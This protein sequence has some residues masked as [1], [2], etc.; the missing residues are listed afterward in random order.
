MIDFARRMLPDRSP[1]RLAYHK[2]KALLAAIRY[3]FPA[4]RLIVTGI[5][6]TDGK[7]TTTA[8]LTHI[9]LTSGMRVG[10]ASTAFMQI[11]EKQFENATHLTSIGPFQLQKFLRHLV[12]ER[13]THVVVEAS[14]HGLSQGRNDWMFPSVAGITNTALEHLD[15]HGTMDQYR[16]DKAI[17]FR[18]L[19]G[20]GTKVL[21]RQDATYATYASIPSAKTITFGSPPAELYLSDV[22]ADPQSCGATLHTPNGAHQ[23]ALPVPGIHNLQNALCA[24]S[25]AAALGVRF[26]DAAKSLGSFRGVPGR[27]ERIDGGQKFSVFVDFAVSPQSYE[28][29][30]EAVR[31][32]I[33]PDK[34]VLVLCGSCGNRMREKRPEIGKICSRLADIVAVTEDETYGEDPKIPWE[35]VWAGVDTS[36]CEAHKI[37]DRREAIAFLLKS[38]Q[39]GDAVLLCGMGPFTTFTKL[40]GRIPWDERQVA[41]EE[42]RKI[43]GA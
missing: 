8:M 36:A 15:Y 32:M 37:F 27:M 41:R 39:P 3:G 14:S 17:L 30:L 13:C 16:R 6:G 24:I 12:N 7:T 33:Q 38:A 21:N 28:K 11:N 9:L 19:R 4:R 20:S 35:E 23:L 43:A 34:K 10:S 2:T 29:T 42:L 18:M 25:C 40:S 31:K 26:A 22:S 1:V 5:T